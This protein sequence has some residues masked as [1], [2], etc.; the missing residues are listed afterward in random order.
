MTASFFSLVLADI[1]IFDLTISKCCCGSRKSCTKSLLQEAFAR[2]PDFKMLL[3][4]PR[5]SIFR[6]MQH[7]V[8]HCYHHNR[9]K[10]T[11]ISIKLGDHI[12]CLGR[13]YAFSL[14]NTLVNV[15]FFGMSDFD[16]DR[17]LFEFCIFPAEILT[18]WRLRDVLMSSKSHFCC[19]S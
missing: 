13:P 2:V 15:C 9:S 16:G 11:R 1:H 18:F 7:Y 17:L 5:G 10:T 12:F 3:W 6:C 8:Y 14:K 19:I 4:P